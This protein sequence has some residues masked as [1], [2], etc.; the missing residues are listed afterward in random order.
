MTAT[1]ARTDG[2]ANATRFIA[3]LGALRHQVMAVA[4]HHREGIRTMKKSDT[5]D[6]NALESALQSYDR[7]RGYGNEVD[8]LSANE[9]VILA[10]GHEVRRLQ[11]LMR[12]APVHQAQADADKLRVP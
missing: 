9:Q 4:H 10:L 2:A 6:V 7:I 5:R 3:P 1:A 11:Q 8:W 12:R